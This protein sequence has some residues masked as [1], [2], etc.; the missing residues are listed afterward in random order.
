MR[1]TLTNWIYVALHF[2]VA[3]K[4]RL[5]SDESDQKSL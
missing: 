5:D 4:E 3:S 1:G 2:M